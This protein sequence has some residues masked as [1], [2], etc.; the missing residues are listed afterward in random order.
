M[1]NIIAALAFSATVTPAWGDAAETVNGKSAV[2]FLLST[3]LPAMDDVTSVEAMARD[4]NWFRLP[5]TAYDSKYT[6]PHLR[7]RANGYMVIIWTFKERNNPS[8]FVGIRPYKKVYSNEFFEAI[9]ASLQLELIS[10]NTYSQHRQ[11]LYKIVGERPL[12]LLLG[13]DLDDTVTTTSIYMD[14]PP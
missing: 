2:D 8:C 1:R 3:C 9:S 7:W 13:S 12:K 6:T 14:P 10:D 5:T 11:R 4:N